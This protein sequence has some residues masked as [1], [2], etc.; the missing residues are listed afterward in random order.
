MGMFAVQI[1]GLASGLFGNLFRFAFGERSRLSFCGARRVGKRRFEFSDASVP[2]GEASAKFFAL[3]TGVGDGRIHAVS[4]ATAPRRSCAETSLCS[5]S[6]YPGGNQVR[7]VFG[8]RPSRWNDLRA[9]QVG[10]RRAASA[11]RVAI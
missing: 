1:A 6:P 2:F 4:V 10:R 9:G 5:R 7:I 11:E 3:G 8:Y